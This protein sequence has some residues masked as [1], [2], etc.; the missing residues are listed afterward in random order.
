MLVTAT[1]T[2]ISAFLLLFVLLVPLVLFLLVL[3]LMVLVLALW[4]HGQLIRPLPPR[5]R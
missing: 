2:L 3:V 5:K 4:W 1:K